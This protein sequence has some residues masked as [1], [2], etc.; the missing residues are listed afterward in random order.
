MWKRPSLESD[1][2]G[3]LPYKLEKCLLTPVY[4]LP[5][6]YLQ[7]RHFR[8][9]VKIEIPKYIEHKLEGAMLYA[10]FTIIF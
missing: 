3:W 6:I 2:M 8:I 10:L 7:N 4:L 1:M 9:A 5:T